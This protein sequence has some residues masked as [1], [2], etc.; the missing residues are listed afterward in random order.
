MDIVSPTIIVGHYGSGK[1]EFTANCARWLERRGQRVLVAD[2]D[3]VNPYFRIREQKEPLGARGIRVVSSNYEDDYYLDTPALAA[4]L[5][6]C[7]E[8]EEGRI[9][10]VDVGGDPAGAVA[11]ARYAGLLK[12]RPYRMWMVVNANRP[13]TARAESV[14][15]YIDAIQRSGRLEI[16]GLISNTHLL[17]DTSPE[18]ILRGDALVREVQAASGLPVV[19]TMIEERLRPQTEHLELLGKPFYISL[20]MRPAC[21]DGAGGDRGKDK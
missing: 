3:I 7:F 14:L 20:A 12:N 15:A 4:S 21:L 9:S 19:C 17:R 13:Q 6:S 11:L 8:P 10:L 1:T 16:N 2:L 18:D 5:R